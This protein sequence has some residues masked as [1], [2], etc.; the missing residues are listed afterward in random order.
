MFRKADA[1]KNLPIPKKTLFELRSFF[2]SIK[3]YVKLV[4]KPLP[5]MFPI[6]P[7]L[8]KRSVYH[9]DK[10]HSF[11]FENLKTHI[12]KLTKNSHFH[13][14]EKTRLK[15]NASHNSLGAALE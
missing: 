3:Q 11:A 2:G 6:P 10:N 8:N 15:T 5:L 1:I 13:I 9:W 7:L 4:Q 12:A 14:K